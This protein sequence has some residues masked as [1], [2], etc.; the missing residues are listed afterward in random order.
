MAVISRSAKNPPLMWQK[1][2]G[3]QLSGE[4][5]LRR[6]QLLAMLTAQGGSSLCSRGQS[7]MVHLL[8]AAMILTRSRD[9]AQFSILGLLAC[10]F[11]ISPLSLKA[12]A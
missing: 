2:S 10:L 5:A 9:L 6:S 1:L 3:V 8:A 4:G 11:R 7:A 12:D